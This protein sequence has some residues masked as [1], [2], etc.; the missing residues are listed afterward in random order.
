MNEYIEILI[1]LPNN[2]MH[3]LK[4]STFEA[5]ILKS[6]PIIFPLH[7]LLFIAVGKL[8]YLLQT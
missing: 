3:A 7:K 1:R 8:F 2:W 4:S 5:S 6:I